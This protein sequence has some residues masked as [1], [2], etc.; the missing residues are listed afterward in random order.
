MP[1]S[2]PGYVDPL[3]VVQD[4][5]QRPVLE[6]SSDRARVN[7]EI[8]HL[9]A[10]YVEAVQKQDLPR[11][12]SK[13][14]T[15]PAAASLRDCLASIV[16]IDDAWASC[17]VSPTTTVIVDTVTVLNPTRATVQLRVLPKGVNASIRGAMLQV[18]LLREGARLD[19]HRLTAE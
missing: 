13:G 16:D 9:V 10:T 17:T 2:G 19:A 8:N 15:V 11:A 3:L 5:A 18:I 7:A 12:A 6:W 14:L 1:P 4:P